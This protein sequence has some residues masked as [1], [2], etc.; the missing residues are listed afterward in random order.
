MFYQLFSLL[1]QPNWHLK[2]TITIRYTL[3]VGGCECEREYCYY[4]V[5][6][7]CPTLCDS[8][9]C[10]LRGSSVEGTSQTRILEWVAMSSSRGSSQPRN[11]TWVLCIAGRFFTIWAKIHRK[12]SINMPWMDE[13]SAS[14]AAGDIHSTCL[15]NTLSPLSSNGFSFT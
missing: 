11:Q 9:H 12:C 7:W 4:L 10:S 5:T 15:P 3:C 6:K 13:W 8:M 1:G 14:G 2:L